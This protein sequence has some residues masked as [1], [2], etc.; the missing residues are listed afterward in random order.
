MTTRVLEMFYC[1]RRSGERETK[2]CLGFLPLPPHPIVDHG[3]W[4]VGEKAV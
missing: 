3:L 4:I 2:Q 1:V